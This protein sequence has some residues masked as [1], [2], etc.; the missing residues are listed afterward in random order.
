[1]SLAV[2]DIAVSWNTKIGHSTLPKL[3][4]SSSL[5]Q[6]L[7]SRMSHRLWFWQGAPR[8]AYSATPYAA[9]PAYPPYGYMPFPP[10]APGRMGGRMG[11][12]PRG[13]GYGGRGGFPPMERPP[14]PGTPGYSSGFQVRL[15]PLNTLRLKPLHIKGCKFTASVKREFLH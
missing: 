9:V 4:K 11:F 8:R 12:P 2:A 6:A 15:A 3:H 10:R 1:M 13:Y 14:P 5:I 7:C